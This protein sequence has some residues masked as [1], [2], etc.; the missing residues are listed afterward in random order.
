MVS[1]NLNGVASGTRG[2]LYLLAL[3]KEKRGEKIIKL[4]TGNP[5][6]FGFEMPRSVKEKLISTLDDALGYSD[7]RGMIEAREAIY[8]YESKMGVLA[9]TPD[10]VFITNGVSEGASLTVSALCS[11][12]DEILLPTPC[13]A[14]WANVVKM[15][16]GKCVFYECDETCGWMPS[17]ENIKSKITKRTKGI[18]VI[19]PNNP[20]GA[21][22]TRKVIE[23]IYKIARENSL[24][25]FSDEIY[26][27]LII[28]DDEHIPAA[29]IGE[30]VLVLTLG[31]LSKS[32]C[33]CGFRAGWVVVSG[34]ED[35][36]CEV[37]SALLTLSAIRMCS[38]TVMQLVIPTALE[39]IEY[40]AQMI[41]RDGRVYRQTTL[42]YE[43]LSKIDGITLAKSNA[44]F[45]L[46]PRLEL[47]RFDISSDIDFAKKL[48][49]EENIL[50]VAGNGFLASDSSHFRLVALQSEEEL[51]LAIKRIAAFLDRHRLNK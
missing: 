41:A 23:E 18:V 37:G 42:A 27:R 10:D 30:D 38:N 51:T 5:A 25:I 15:S 39:D 48:L 26:D 7:V 11:P 50:V 46:Y 14:L 40:T 45:Y 1:T 47:D 29:S 44:A 19:N 36:R 34:P 22:Y 12:G 28:S 8:K 2:E 21:V 49:L 43:L 31:G 3:E 24:V 16:G 20:T 6:D 13:Y 33:L 32:H 17:V 35:K 9:T 4:N